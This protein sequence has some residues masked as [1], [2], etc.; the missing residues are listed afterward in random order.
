[1]ALLNYNIVLNINFSVC[2]INMSEAFFRSS[3]D[4]ENVYFR[5]KP[6]VSEGTS[7]VNHLMQTVPISR[8]KCP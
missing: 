2:I 3:M 7:E 4:S 6:R 8:I 5:I 1:M